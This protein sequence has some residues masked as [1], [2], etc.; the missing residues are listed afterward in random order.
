[1]ARGLDVGM[2]HATR[3]CRHWGE[4]CGYISSA[5]HEAL[6]G[7]T[8]LVSLVAII[9]FFSISVRAGAG[10]YDLAPKAYGAMAI[11]F[12]TALLATHYYVHQRA[13]ARP[14]LALVWLVFVTVLGVMLGSFLLSGL[15]APHK[16]GITMAVF[17]GLPF[18]VP[19]FFCLCT[20]CI[21][22][23]ACCCLP[24]MALF[25]QYPQQDS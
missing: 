23:C 5:H 6:Q 2:R 14:T 21:G 9:A 4:E 3:L 11:I 8:L 12:P 1:M 7:V 17:M 25:S 16:L 19:T 15:M 20:P 18:I 22:C 13:E 10:H 24:C